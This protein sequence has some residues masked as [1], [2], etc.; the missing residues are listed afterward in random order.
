MKAYVRTTLVG[1]EYF[2]KAGLAVSLLPSSQLRHALNPM[3]L[4][5]PLPC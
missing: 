4:R 5:W 1:F 2:E 3:G